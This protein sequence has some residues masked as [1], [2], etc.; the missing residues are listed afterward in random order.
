MIDK[1][2]YQN[3]LSGGLTGEMQMSNMGA[4]IDPLAGGLGGGFKTSFNLLQRP[5]EN[6]ERQYFYNKDLNKLFNMPGGVR[7][8]APKGFESVNKNQYE[9]FASKGATLQGASMF[10]D[11]MGGGYNLDLPR[12]TSGE[13]SGQVDRNS[14][15]FL[16]YYGDQ[17]QPKLPPKLSLGPAEGV[18]QDIFGNPNYLDGTRSVQP[19][20]TGPQEIATQ[21]APMDPYN[22][23]G[24]QLM[25][26]NQD[27]MLGTLKNIEQGIASL[28]GNYGQDFNSNKSSNYGDFDN[29]GMGSFF[30]PYGGM[31]G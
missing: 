8:A 19:I 17:Q 2:L 21:Q 18:S 12:L 24:Q 28:V 29:F 27:E 9:D 10:N 3:P 4:K 14:P 20:V 6:I 23:V 5:D 13:N 1:P 30:P 11:A 22:R 26:P 15:E 31:Y 25:G 7:M 16:Y